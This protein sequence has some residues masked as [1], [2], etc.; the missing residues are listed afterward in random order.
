MLGLW[1]RDT[2][3]QRKLRLKERYEALGFT[4]R[5]L[6]ACPYED[7]KAE[8]RRQRRIAEVSREM[9]DVLREL[10]SLED[11]ERSHSSSV[12]RRQSP[13]VGHSSE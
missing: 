13:L 10:Q 9:G 7:H 6:R 1:F 11:A 4:W 12:N 3:L 2:P 8:D 5:Q